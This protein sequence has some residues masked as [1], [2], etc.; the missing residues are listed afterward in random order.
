MMKKTKIPQISCEGRPLRSA[1]GRP[2][3]EKTRTNRT[4]HG[5]HLHTSEFKQ[6]RPILCLC[7]EGWFFVE[8]KSV[9]RIMQR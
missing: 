3:Q 9:L 4:G 2:V 8:S 1:D 5:N 6:A 7:V